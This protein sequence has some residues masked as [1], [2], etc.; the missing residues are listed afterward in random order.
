MSL[1]FIIYDDSPE[2]NLLRQR[3]QQ[4]LRQ[5]PQQ[6]ALQHLQ[7]QLHQ[8]PQQRALRRPQH[9]LQLPVS[10]MLAACLSIP[11]SIFSIIHGAGTTTTY[12]LYTNTFTPTS[13][14]TTVTFAFQVDD[15]P[16]IWDLD[17]VSLKQTLGIELM[18]NG[19][20]ESG[21]LSPTWNTSCTFQCTGISSQGSGGGPGG[22]STVYLH[23]GT[24]NYRDRCNPEPK[25][26]YLS[27]TI[28]TVIP[29]QLCTLKYYLALYVS[30][31]KV[32]NNFYVIIS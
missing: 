13:N 19:G 18:L 10:L 22:I 6:R 29:N 23:T 8:R 12:Q 1:K 20:I 4:Q 32:N 30:N 25:F 14:V 15:D 17:D 7:Q 24:Y 9:Q 21:S 28:T 27:Q 3:L 2:T 26:D 5:R 11:T 16:G 31:N